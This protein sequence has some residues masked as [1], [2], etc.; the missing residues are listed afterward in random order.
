MPKTA[1]R[2][3]LSTARR[4]DTHTAIVES[5]V[6]DDYGEM[7]ARKREAA[8]A[9]RAHGHEMGVWKRRNDAYGRQD[10]WCRI[11]GAIMTVCVE[12]PAAYS[13]PFVYGK[14]L[15]DSCSITG[16]QR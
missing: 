1:K 3:L 13:L 14:A 11:C 2:G 16:G 8:A 5:R 7:P 9:A 6:V 4:A 12:A 15:T 10:S